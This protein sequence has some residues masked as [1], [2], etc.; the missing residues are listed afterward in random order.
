MRKK[1]PPPLPPIMCR[2]NL[3]SSVDFLVDL[4]VDVVGLGFCGRC[5]GY[6]PLHWASSFL[7][8]HL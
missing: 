4:A 7:D 2:E 5:M 6:L 3:I 8:P 1:E